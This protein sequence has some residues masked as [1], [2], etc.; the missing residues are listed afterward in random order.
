MEEIIFF[1]QWNIGI[2]KFGVLDKF[3]INA[4]GLN[5]SYFILRTSFTLFIGTQFS[6]D[7]IECYSV[8]LHGATHAW[9]KPVTRRSQYKTRFASKLDELSFIYIVLESLRSSG[10]PA[11]WSAQESRGV[12]FVFRFFI[13]KGDIGPAFLYLFWGRSTGA[14]TSNRIIYS[15]SLSKEK[16]SESNRLRKQR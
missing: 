7:Q 6:I 4:E 9:K 3:G 5:A 16:V 13:L 8:S 11:I 2:A 15:C 10:W 12:S 14:R 1:G